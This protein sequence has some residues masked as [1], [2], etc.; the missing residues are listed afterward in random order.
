VAESSTVSQSRLKRRGCLEDQR[1]VC[2]CSRDQCVGPLEVSDKPDREDRHRRARK[3]RC[4]SEAGRQPTEPFITSNR[5]LISPQ[6]SPPGTHLQTQRCLFS[7]AP[8]EHSLP[9]GT[10]ACSACSRAPL[11]LLE[12]PKMTVGCFDHPDLRAIINSNAMQVPSTLS[13]V[14]THLDA[15]VIAPLSCRSMRGLWTG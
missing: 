14:C 9:T 10:W 6:N 15:V 1:E 4:G 2:R 3:E 8:A 7:L 11:T 5:Q 12:R 13:T